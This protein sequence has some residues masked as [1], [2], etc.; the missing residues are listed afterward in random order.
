[1]TA[2]CTRGKPMSQRS[3]R[4]TRRSVLATLTLASAGTLLTACG[5]GA[6]TS[7]T[8][9]PKADSKPTSAPAA[10]AAQ[11]AST[12]PAEAAKPTTAPASKP[13]EAT[14]PASGDGVGLITGPFEGEAKALNGAGA[15]FPAA[16]YSKWFDEYFKLTGVEVNYQS[17]GS[18]GG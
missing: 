10:P 3:P 11:P 16:L 14:K 8:A 2:S 5:S 12:R 4:Y 6:A 1:M 7:P 13:A 17:I 18:G 15:T 9:A